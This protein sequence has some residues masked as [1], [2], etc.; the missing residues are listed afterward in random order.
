[1]SGDGRSPSSVRKVGA[2]LTRKPLFRM[3]P[4]DS[5]WQCDNETI[6]TNAEYLV[7]QGRSARALEDVRTSM[8]R[9]AESASALAR[10]PAAAALKIGSHER[11]T[12]SN[13]RKEKTESSKVLCVG[14]RTYSSL[15]ANYKTHTMGCSK[16]QYNRLT[17]SN[18]KATQTP[19]CNPLPRTTF[20]RAPS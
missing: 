20:D 1:M 7:C 8:L 11:L 3:L 12:K 5:L 4:S 15:F 6:D 16:Q 19:H 13:K 18:I 2:I 14:H 17:K 10:R 9:N